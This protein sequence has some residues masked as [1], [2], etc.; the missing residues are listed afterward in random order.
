MWTDKY[1]ENT[2]W[3]REIRR[4]FCKPDCPRNI[5]PG[6]GKRD[7]NARGWFNLE[8][9]AECMRTWSTDHSRRRRCCGREPNIGQWPLCWRARRSKFRIEQPTPETDAPPRHRVSHTS[10][11]CTAEPETVNARFST[12][13][14][15]SWAHGHQWKTGY[16]SRLTGFSPGYA[17]GTN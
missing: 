7:C 9:W 15:T 14:N 12:S 6:Y 11:A 2:H 5:I 10:G 3:Q 4:N 17:T 1:I 16:Q 8:S 13:S